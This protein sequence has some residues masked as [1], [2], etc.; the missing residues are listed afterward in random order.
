MKIKVVM[1]SSVILAFALFIEPS[2]ARQARRTIWD[3]VY[4]QDQA[5]TGAELMGQCRGCH[6][7]DFSGGQAPALRGSKWM[8]YWRE[9]T[10]DSMYSLIKESMPPRAGSAMSESQA[11]SVVAYILQ[12]NDLPSGDS[13]L[14]TYD[15]PSI[16]IESRNGPEPL[17]TYAVVQVVGCTAKGEGENW[18]IERT[19]VPIR[20]RNSGRASDIE[21]KAAG[22]KILGTQSYQLQNLAMAGITSSSMQEGHKVLVKGVLLPDGHL[23]VNSL[24]EVSTSCGQ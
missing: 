14:S 17:P 6:G 24:Q 8:E 3:G 21:L 19:T 5:A 13:P 9:D 12:A 16:H 7:G 4:T 18:N 1:A 2:G 15:L 20:A 11:L 22:A 10:L 23:G